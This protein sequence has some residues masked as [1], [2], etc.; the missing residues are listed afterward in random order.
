MAR[1]RKVRIGF[2]IVKKPRPR[3]FAPRLTNER[4]GTW[5][6]YYKLTSRKRQL[7][8]LDELA[9]RRFQFSYYGIKN[10]EGDV[11]PVNQNTIR[12]FRVKHPRRRPA[13]W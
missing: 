11:M 12:S 8:E 1:P 4:L 2:K 7:Q 9:D 6:K 13:G 3:L 10:K 5:F